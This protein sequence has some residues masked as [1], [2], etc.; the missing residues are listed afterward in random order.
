MLAAMAWCVTAA[1]PAQG[2]TRVMP[3]GDSI[4]HG[5]NVPGGYRIALED[6]LIAAGLDVDFV[7]SQ[8]NG[9]RE[10]ADRQ[11][12]GYPG[13]RIDELSRRVDPLVAG[14]RPE[15]VLLLIG[16]NDMIGN[17]RLAT[18]PQRL[19]S[20]IDQIS[21][22]ARG[23]PILVA[24]LPTLEKT[25]GDSSSS[26]DGDRRVR[27]YNAAIPRVVADQVARGRR[28][29]FVDM[30]PA[31]DRSDLADRVHPNR[32]G[33]N[34]MAAVWESAL[35]VTLRPAPSVQPVTSPPEAAPAPQTPSP[36]PPPPA[37]TAPQVA[38]PPAPAAAAPVRRGVR[39][40]PQ[41]IR[42]DRRGRVRVRV[43]CLSANPAPCR[44]SISLRR[45]GRRDTRLATGQFTVRA[46][47]ASGVSLRLSG[48]RRRSI[49][50]QATRVVICTRVRDSSGGLR[51]Q[52]AR[53]TLRLASSRS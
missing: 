8:A 7:G 15:V 43:R 47:R 46:G 42:M 22:G 30:Y 21:A 23:A 1:A 19:S 50:L 53:A 45:A 44:G 12:E 35:R 11:H 20:L 3:L 2:V 33:Y 32:T 24:S 41:S 4:T 27:A 34:K 9:P 39:V 37:A 38:Q 29:S 14:N 31:L 16:T 48:E 13:D 51:T 5:Y 17:Y 25:D 18:A 6:R 28:V 36:A 49:S 26:G 40:A 10:L 52:R